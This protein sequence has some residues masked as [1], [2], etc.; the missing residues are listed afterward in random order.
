MV[1]PANDLT[2]YESYLS[3]DSVACFDTTYDANSPGVLDKS[4]NS[5]LSRRWWWL[6]CNEPT[7][8]AWEV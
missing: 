6:T 7:M 8:W 2:L 4:P 1:S 3:P 5:I